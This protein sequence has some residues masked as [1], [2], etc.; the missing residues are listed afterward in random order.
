VSSPTP[1]PSFAR[2]PQF[3][4]AHWAHPRNSLILRA[5]FVPSPTHHPV[6]PARIGPFAFPAASPFVPRPA[7]SSARPSFARL[8]GPPPIPLRYSQAPPSPRIP[9][10]YIGTQQLRLRPASPAAAARRRSTS[11]AKCARSA[12]CRT[13]PPP[14]PASPAARFG[15]RQRHAP[16]F[17]RPPTPSSAAK[18]VLCR[19]QTPS[20]AAGHERH[21]ATFSRDLPENTG[22]PKL[23]SRKSPRRRSRLLA[24]ATVIQAPTE[25][26]REVERER[27]KDRPP[28][29][30]SIRSSATPQHPALRSTRFSAIPQYR[31]TADFRFTTKSAEVTEFPLYHQI[32]RNSALASNRPQPPIPGFATKSATITKSGVTTKS[33]SITDSPLYRQSAIT[34]DSPLSPEAPRS[35]LSSKGHGWGGP[36]GWGGPGRQGDQPHLHF[37]MPIDRHEGGHRL[38]PPVAYRWSSRP[39]TYAALLSSSRG[40]TATGT[41]SS[42]KTAAISRWPPSASM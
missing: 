23:P 15:R 35:R 34:V 14:A 17:G 42:P 28:P 13:R 40:P 25:S 16:S 18:P 37:S 4:P 32:G 22:P 2:H 9:L 29:Y 30:R 7:P 27:D 6:S 1:P 19:G 11:S 33:A 12:P 21:H 5:N 41:W 31:H 24:L 38:S 39:V 26:A 36:R 3:R 10:R 8:F 20:S